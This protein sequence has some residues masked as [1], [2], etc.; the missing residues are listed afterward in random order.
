MSK[1]AT[2]PTILSFNKATFFYFFEMD[3]FSFLDGELALTYGSE[4]LYFDRRDYLGTRVLLL[5]L[6]DCLS[7]MGMWISLTVSGVRSVERTGRMVLLAWLV[8]LSMDSV[9]FLLGLVRWL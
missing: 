6:N 5:F 8:A 2:S 3:R 1:A 9:A 4:L 7:W